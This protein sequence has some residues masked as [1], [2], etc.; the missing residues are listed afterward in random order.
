MST[1]VCV[2]CNGWGCTHCG[3]AELAQVAKAGGEQGPDAHDLEV[4][5][6]TRKLD[7]ARAEVERLT[8]PIDGLSP[9][10]VY[11]LA[12]VKRI[13]QVRGKP[14]E[15][16]R[17]TVAEVDRLRG[18]SRAAIEMGTWPEPG[19]FERH[20]A[21]CVQADP[22]STPPTGKTTYRVA[23]VECTRE[24]FEAA[25]V[26]AVFTKPTPPE[27]PRAKAIEEALTSLGAQAQSLTLV[28]C[29]KCGTETAVGLSLSGEPTPYVACLSPSC[30]F[31][32]KREG[33]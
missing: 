12:D 14:Y 30:D 4:A 15:R 6:L 8:R 27:R 20:L 2:H 5:R 1:V 21:E 9:G 23:G 22:Q 11:T 7:E 10:P 32:T 25:R 29:P 19:A 28:P 26:V 3:K 18:E 24:Q 13:E 31:V 17:A 16:L 33:T